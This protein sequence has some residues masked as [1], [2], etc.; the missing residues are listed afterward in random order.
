M[1]G[2]LIAGSTVDGQLGS[3]RECGR[4]TSSW[5]GLIPEVHGCDKTAVHSEYVE[6]LAVRKNIPLKALDELV[7][8]D[9]VLASVFLGHCE[10]F[11]MVIDLPPLSSPIGAVRFFSENFASTQSHGPAPVCR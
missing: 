11:D 8:P 6:N 9:A 4:R 1:R 5:I 7:H 3:M 2:V 10:R